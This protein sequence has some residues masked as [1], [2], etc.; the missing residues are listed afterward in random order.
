MIGTSRGRIIVSRLTP[1]NH[2]F[3]GPA[4]SFSDSLLADYIHKPIQLLYYPPYHSK[5]NPI[6]RCWG[7]LELKW[8]GTK[9]ID[10]ETMVEWAKRMTWKGRSPVV[11]L[12]RKVYQKGIALGKVA[13]QAVEERLERHPALPK[14]DIL[15]NPAPTS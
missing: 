1:G 4:D 3:I 11:E 2:R 7:I 5:Y 13:M 15:I 6:E 14:Y 9:L 10:A 12:S 8:N